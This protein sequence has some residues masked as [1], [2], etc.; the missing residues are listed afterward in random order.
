MQTDSF[1]L[2]SLCLQLRSEQIQTVRP[3]LVFLAFQQG[4][5]LV[6][7]ARKAVAPLNTSLRKLPTTQ[8]L[9]ESLFTLAT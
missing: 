2:I 3:P 4:R 7:T 6:E 1:H 8:N 9:T 5:S